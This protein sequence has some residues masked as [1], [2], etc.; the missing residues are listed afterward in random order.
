MVLKHECALESLRSLAEL[1]ILGVQTQG[2]LV[3]GEAEPGN[4]RV[5][6]QGHSDAGR[7][8]T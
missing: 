7:P 8:H 4:Q 5:D 2:I 3:L 1:L 6:S